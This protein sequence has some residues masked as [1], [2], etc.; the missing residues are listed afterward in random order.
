MEDPKPLTTKKPLSKKDLIEYLQKAD[1]PDE[2]A[3]CT[4][5]FDDKE[6]VFKLYFYWSE[7]AGAFGQSVISFD[8]EREFLMHDCL[9]YWDSLGHDESNRS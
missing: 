3:E 8:I 6:G 2:D 7:S 9:R 5:L 4:L 1:I